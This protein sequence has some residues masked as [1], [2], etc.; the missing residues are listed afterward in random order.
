M[1]SIRDCESRRR[2]GADPSVGLGQ[3]RDRGKSGAGFP[4][5]VQ[6]LNQT[7]DHPAAEVRPSQLRPFGSKIRA[8]WG[9][10]SR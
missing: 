7:L 3:P 9:R 5:A 8:I 10:C 2:G 1:P 4:V 6:A